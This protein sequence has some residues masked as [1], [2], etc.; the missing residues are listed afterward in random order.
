MRARMAKSSMSILF[1]SILLL[2]SIFCNCGY[3]DEN[4]QT[5][6][7]TV[8]SIDWV[9]SVISVSGMRF[10]IMPDTR[11]Y[12]G[13]TAIPFSEINTNDSVDV[14]YYR[15]SSGALRATSIMVHYSGDFPI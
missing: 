14:T 4:R 7:G 10:I 9:G 5:I 13:D 11:I 1:F 12:K 6:T 2:V 15:D 3:A 8:D